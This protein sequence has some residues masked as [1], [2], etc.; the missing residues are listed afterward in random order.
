MK[1]TLIYVG[2]GVAGFN[3]NRP[4]GDREGSWIGHGI[5]SI[6]ANAKKAGH[7]IDLIDMRQLSSFDDL[8]AMIKLSPSPVYGLS[9]SAVDYLPA[10][11]TAVVI[12]KALP[13]S[14][15]IIGGIHPS[16]FPEKYDYNVIDTVVQ[17][18]GEI[19]FVNLL[20]SLSNGEDLPKVTRGEKPDLN[21]I[22]WVDRTLF[23]YSQEL[24]CFFAHDQECPS[25]TMLAGRG[26]PYS[27]AY[28]QPAENAVYGKPHR[29]RSPEDVVSELL[30]LKEAYDFKSITFWDDTF[31]FSY[32]WVM[33]FCD[34]YEATEIKASIVTCSRAD[35]VC[36]HPDMIKRLA[37]IG[38]TWLVIG[39]E[40]GSQ[41]I[42]DFIKKGI[43]VEQNIEAARICR[44]NGIKVFATH[45]YGLPTETN[46]EALATKQMIDLINP[47][48]PSPFWFIPI[49]GTDLYDYCIKHDLLLGNIEDRTIAR[50]N[51]FSPAIKGVDYE[52]IKNLMLIPEEVV[53]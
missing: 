26:C 15:V 48:H 47:E 4:T 23:N 11:K 12:K 37:E 30:Y 50:T 45:M 19:T 46:E 10:L 44:E 13:Q 33:E 43:T 34:I 42:L 1:A 17:G 7:N 29:M 52:Y 24:S 41:R 40:S 25:V 2:I 38:V 21:A 35:I 27:C 31:T 3:N 18:E 6:G 51:I 49:E 22:P 39:M 20:N 28:C 16:I 32:K 8:E 53:V 9:V 14:K 5:A 36:K